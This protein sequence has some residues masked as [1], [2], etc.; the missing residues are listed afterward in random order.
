MLILETQFDPD[1]YWQT[2]EPAYCIA[3]ST[4]HNCELT[5]EWTRRRE[6]GAKSITGFLLLDDAFYGPVRSYVPLLPTIILYNFLKFFRLDTIWMVARAPLLLNAIIVAAPTDLAVFYI[7]SYIFKDAAVHSYKTIPLKVEHWALLASTTN[8]FN[9][10]ALIRTYSNSLETVILILGISLLCPELFGEPCHKQDFKTRMAFRIAF[11]LGGVGVVIRFTALAAW[12]PIG[13][14][15]CFRRRLFRAKVYYFCNACLYGATGVVLGCVVDRYFYGFWAIPFLGSFH[16]NALLGNGALYGTHPWFWYIVAGLPAIVG[17]LTVPFVY[18]VFLCMRRRNLRHAIWGRMNVIQAIIVSYVSLHSL[19][20]HKEL[21]FML[22]VLPLICI[23]SGYTL[24]IFCANTYSSK[25]R[26][27]FVLT[28]LLV[29]NYPHLMFL[30]TVHQ[31]APIQVN[32]V[33]STYIKDMATLDDIESKRFSIHYLMGCHSTPLYSHL[34]VTKK[35]GVLD[36]TVPIDTWYLDCSP[37]CRSDSLQ[38]CESEEFSNNPR[39]FVTKY[40]S[41]PERNSRICTDEKVCFNNKDTDKSQT[42]RKNIPDFLAMFEHDLNNP[43]SKDLKD[44]L[45]SMGLEETDK[46]K[47]A[48]K[49]ISLIRLNSRNEKYPDNDV[50]VRLPGRLG[51]KLQFEH[52]LVFTNKQ[53]N[54]RKNIN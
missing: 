25:G 23:I 18:N 5:W 48:V 6:P 52:M 1:E 38:L 51:L 9:G 7:S 16:F 13:M 22:P 37:E 26:L 33:L 3:F 11:L 14:I 10:Y 24:Y 35:L 39:G 27:L 41:I 53:L 43:N 28:T 20:A 15:V 45:I 21:R 19:S 29:M 34:H 2:L 50:L 17:I 12:I 42:S 40:Y 46:I 36:E 32:K 8:W 4:G 31:R 54:V 44:V 47:H 30:C 49:G